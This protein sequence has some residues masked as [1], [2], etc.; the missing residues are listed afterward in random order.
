MCASRLGPWR[1][2]TLAG[3]HERS[4]RN[5]F[6]L[7]SDD[8]LWPSRRV[9][10]GTMEMQIGGAGRGGGSV[11]SSADL[12]RVLAAVAPAREQRSGP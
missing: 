3:M 7:F 4:Y 12:A 9:H 10:A 8:K 5:V 6:R 11:A 1:Y 2:K